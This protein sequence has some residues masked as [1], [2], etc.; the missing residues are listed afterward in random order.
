MQPSLIRLRLDTDGGCVQW[1]VDWYDERGKRAGG[2]VTS[3]D[4]FPQAPAEALEEA[5]RF[6]SGTR[7]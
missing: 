5:I 3:C 2:L 1:A 6:L 4:P 7:K